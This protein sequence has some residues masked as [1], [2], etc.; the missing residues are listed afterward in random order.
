MLYVPECC[1]TGYLTL[2]DDSEIYYNT[3]EFY[4]P[5]VA[6]GIRYDDPAFGIEW[7]AEIKVLS[8]NDENW[9]GFSA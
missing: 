3:S 6:T 2:E 4:A 5:E 8:D 7:P 9:P 1:A